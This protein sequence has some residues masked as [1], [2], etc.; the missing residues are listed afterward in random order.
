[1]KIASLLLLTLTAAFCQDQDRVVRRILDR[2]P[3][4]SS[5]EVVVHES[6]LRRAP[7]WRD[8][9]ES[10]PL[11]PQQAKRMAKAYVSQFIPESRNWRVERLSLEPINA[12]DQWIYVVDF[13]P[14]PIGGS[15]F[16]NATPFQIVILL[17][18]T[19]LQPQMTNNRKN[20]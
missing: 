16:G 9:E 7:L 17:D 14:V 3:S 6:D 8:D 13:C 5:Y 10:P 4:G 12:R 1:M 11:S 19:L 20:I 2:H 15:T 18:G